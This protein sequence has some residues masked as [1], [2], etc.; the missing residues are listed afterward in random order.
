MGTLEMYK[1]SNQF[2]LLSSGLLFMLFILNCS[3]AQHS[4]IREAMAAKMGWYPADATELTIMVDQMLAKAKKT[5][6]NGTIIGLVSP[7]AGYFYSG[8]VAANSY[9]L[10]KGSNIKRVV[11]IAPSHISAFD[12]VS[13]YDGD[14]YATPLGNIQ[15]DHNFADKLVKRSPLIK[16]SAKG[17]DETYMGRGEHS[18]EAQLP[19]LQRVLK[20]F[21]LVPI[22]MGEQDYRTCRELGIALAEIVKPGET[23]IAA[24]S[25]LSHFHSYDQAVKLDRSVIRSIEEWDY[26]NLSRN[27]QGRIWEACGGGPIIATMI[28][29]ERVGA[30]QAKLIQYANSGDTAGGNR[31]SV[32]GYAAIAFIKEIKT[33]SRIEHP[34]QIS[35][36][37]QKKLLEI[38][39]KS[40]ETMI[41]E[42]KIYKCTADDFETLNQERGAFVT[43]KKEG[44]LRGCI[45][46]TAPIKPLYQTV[47]EAAISAAT[48]DPRFSPVSREELD[49]LNY[50]ISVLSPFTHVQDIN[51]IEIGKHGLLIKYG[52][53]EGLLLPQ[54]ATE[55]GWDLDTF[56]Q[57]T[58]LKA[59]LPN[60]TWK[61]QEADIFKFSAF[62]F[63]EH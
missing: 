42:R 6:I 45:G 9:A 48:K 34:F 61:D 21:K 39:K 4:K 16:R 15:I 59:G 20:E 30:T 35:E 22:I 13:I 37:E 3:D 8:H 25:D 36:A 27:L 55:Q 51:Q 47:Q 7:H 31:E 40:V 11:V 52:S 28:A 23:I 5:G 1:K 32:V 41:K 44:N 26:F 46:Y 33:S 53:R 19:F 58:C 54:V 49:D 29:A 17:H 57:H 10:L 18:L 56:L 38:A 2:L 62:V 14:A 63:G 24:S 12:G 50:E 60:E 43:L